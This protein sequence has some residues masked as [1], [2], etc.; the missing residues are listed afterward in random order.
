M[1]GARVESYVTLG[2]DVE[3]EPGAV[4]E[5]SVVM[6]GVR[7]AADAVVAHSILGPGVQIGHGERVQGEVRAA[8]EAAQPPRA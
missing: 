2:N 6:D 1:E 7:V 3:L 8:S 4:V 5:D